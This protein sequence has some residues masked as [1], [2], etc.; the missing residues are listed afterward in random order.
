MNR[1]F[2]ERALDYYS[3]PYDPEV[4]A[5]A[6][7]LLAADEHD[8]IVA[9]QQAYDDTLHRTWPLSPE[10][11]EAAR[12]HL[13]DFATLARAACRAWRGRAWAAVFAPDH[14]AHLDPATGRGD[15]GEDVPEDMHLFHC[16]GVFAA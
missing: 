13:D 4:L 16:Y 5:R 14:G 11:L 1:C 9:Y 7:T 3:E 6:T 10:C 2:R 15:H 8:V 12:S